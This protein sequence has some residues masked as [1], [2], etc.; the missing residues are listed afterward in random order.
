MNHSGLESSTADLSLHDGKDA[1]LDKRCEGVELELPLVAGNLSPKMVVSQ[2]NSLDYP[3][4]ALNI[5]QSVVIE[6][7]FKQARGKGVQARF[8]SDKQ[9]RSATS[10]HNSFQILSHD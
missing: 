3:V 10:F 5:D 6:R 1:G 2:K 7:G 4:M 9:I 8:P